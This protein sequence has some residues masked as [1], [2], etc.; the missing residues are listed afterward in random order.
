MRSATRRVIGVAAV[1]GVVVWLRP[2]TH[3][4]RRARGQIERAARRL[5][6]GAGR[7][8][9]LRYRLAGLGPDPG[10]ADPVLA[11]RVRSSLGPLEKRLDVPHIHVMVEDHVAL[12]H[13]EVPSVWAAM[14]LEGAV[15]AVPGIAGV[16]SYLHI[17]LTRGDTR[18]SE[19]RAVHQRS[20][21]LQRLLEAAAEAGAPLGDAHAAVRWV[22]ATFADR[23]PEGERAQVAAHLP[24]DVRGLFEPPRR[25]RRGTPVR[26]V[27]DL[28]E[29]VA[30][31]PSGLSSDSAR[32]VTTAVLAVLRAL[33]PEEEGDV[34]A[35]LPAELR[36]L[37]EGQP[38]A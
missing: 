4:N 9:G 1:G 16:D 35:V 14:E 6:Y 3:A 33:V 10:A 7:L 13:G 22:L 12:L 29:R 37:W 24:G 25:L 19:G 15:A 27:D 32:A 31:A 17:G 8:E 36:A 18:P 34:A 2:G 20:P 11:D 23:L 30:A 38:T 26:S 5:R 28:V 21:A